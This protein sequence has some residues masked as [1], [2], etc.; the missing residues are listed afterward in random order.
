VTSNTFFS[1]LAFLAASAAVACAQQPGV[2]TVP[3]PP[4]LVVK[5]AENPSYSLKVSIKPGYHANS[6]TPSEDYLIPIRLT[7][8]AGALEVVEVVY[9]KPKHEK[10]A[11]SEKPLS[12]FDGD[13]E[14]V[15]R[16]KRAANPALGPGFLT[17]KLRYQAC[18]DK[19]CLPPKNVEIK[20]PVLMQ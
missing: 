19:M 5:R 12:I 2:L 4:K 14:I 3:D 20:L 9:P 6:N 1:S 17:G 15:T 8:E 13:F 10:F 18:N 11:F 7:W 16:F